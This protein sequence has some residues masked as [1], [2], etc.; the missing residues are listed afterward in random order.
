MHLL[1]KRRIVALLLLSSCLFA[2]CWPGA[3]T[4]NRPDGP[5]LNVVLMLTMHGLV[6]LDRQDGKQRWT[7]RPPGWQ[8][9]QESGTGPLIIVDGVV[10]WKADRLY[11]IHA[12]DGK[13]LWSTVLD[14]R[15]RSI[16]ISVASD[17]VYTTI[18]STV[19]AFD[20]QNGRLVWKKET[21]IADATGSVQLLHTVNGTTLYVWGQ[22][23]LFALDTETGATRWEYRQGNAC[24]QIT[25]V[26]PHNDLILVQAGGRGTQ[27]SNTILGLQASDG[28]QRWQIAVPNYDLF[29][30]ALESLT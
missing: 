24:S 30:S 18:S 23:A 21:G 6:A 8:S 7:F 22:Q 29:R 9:P 16:F 27:A 4:A 1:L 12:E 19:Y 10:Y 26:M 14:A 15:G 28:H 2:G 17:L 20:K 13:Q 5:S 25:T 3:Q 11:A